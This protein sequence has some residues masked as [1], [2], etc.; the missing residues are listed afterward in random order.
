MSKTTAFY[1]D[2]T[3][4]ALEIQRELRE[5]TLRLAEYERYYGM[6]QYAVNEIREP[7]A[8]AYRAAEFI[9]LAGASSRASSNRLS[10]QHPYPNR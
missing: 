4:A 6:D 2:A 7:L 9:E 5:A 8:R 10:K 3:G 1:E